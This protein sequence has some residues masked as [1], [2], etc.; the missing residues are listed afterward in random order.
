MIN[1]RIFTV[2][3]NR[4]NARCTTKILWSPQ[5]IFKVGITVILQMAN[6]STD[7]QGQ[8]VTENDKAQTVNPNPDLGKAS[9]RPAPTE[10]CTCVIP[11]IAGF[12]P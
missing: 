9:L 10:F 1:K 3:S 7:W 6:G 2:Q 12:E 4:Q 8:K 5:K 11:N